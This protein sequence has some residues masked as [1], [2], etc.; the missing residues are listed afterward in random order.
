[1]RLIEMHDRM[2]AVLVEAQQKRDS[3]PD[4]VEHEMVA[5]V[6]AVNRERRTRRRDEV[7]RKQVED[8]EIHAQG[9]VDYSRKFALYCAELVLS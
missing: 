2:L 9:H 3:D 7:T 1:M 4:W 5:M 8:V 6:D